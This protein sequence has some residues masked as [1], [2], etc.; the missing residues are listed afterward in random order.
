[1]IMR[2]PH[3]WAP[4]TS[5]PWLAALLAAL[6]CLAALAL[7]AS[8]ATA[9]DHRVKGWGANGSWQLGEGSSTADR[10]TPS[11]IP[12]L[13][14]TD[15]KALTTGGHATNTGFGLALLDNGTVEA[16]GY[17]AHGQLGDSTSS[18]RALPGT[19]P[20]LNDVVAIASGG[21]HNLALLSDGTVRAWGYNA[22]G[23]LG[24]GTATNRFTPVV[25]QG[26][27]NVVAIA[28]GGYHSLALRGDGTVWAWGYNAQGQIGDATTANRTTPVPVQNLTGARD[29]AAGGHH[30]LAVVSDGTVRAWGHNPN[31]ELGDGTTTGRTT[32]VPVANLR[33]VKDI[34]AGG[35]HNVAL[36][37]NGTLRTWGYNAQGQIGDGTTTNSPLP[38]EVTDTRITTV[39][40]IAAGG[41]HTLALRRDGT[42]LTWG[43][44]ANGQLGDGTATN[45]T[46][47]VTAITEN[48]HTTKIAAPVLG[49]HS[50]AG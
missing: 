42:V 12:G 46:T 6:T 8:V 3:T 31:G 24:D 41:T 11:T 34:T 2:S 21:L 43:N 18:S 7:P 19:V 13:T 45:R 15:L 9:Q 35:N 16:W 4:P 22:H 39:E 36:L 1:M 25:V 28:A 5:T 20:G 38:V 14:G 50:Y 10:R 32:P 49:Q 23:Q 17:N 29:I 27:D 30:S 40:A 47:P 33:D 48:S 37:T 44:N 26:L